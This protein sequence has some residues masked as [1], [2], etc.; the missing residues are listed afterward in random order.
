MSMEIRKELK[1]NQLLRDIYDRLYGNKKV[2]KILK[3]RREKLQKCG[4]DIVNKVEIALGDSGVMYFVAY[5][6]LLG[7]YRDGKFMDYDDDLDYGIFITDNFTWE[8]LEEKLVSVGFVKR[9]EFWHNN[10][11]AEQ[12]YYMDDVPIDFF[13]FYSKDKN[14]IGKSFIRINHKKYDSDD[15]FS[16]ATNTFEVI[17]GI[18][19]MDVNGYQISVPNDVE[20]FLECAY[21]KKWKVPDSTWNDNSN[22]LYKIYEDELGIEKNF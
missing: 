13:G 16:Y 15:E 10:E 5:G 17:D 9:K 1:K 11:I 7:L 19:K 21:T 22:P 12:T 14:S 8:M 3:R 4:M 6:S 2:K 18:K 20:M